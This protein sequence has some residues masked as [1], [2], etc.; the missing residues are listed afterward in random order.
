MEPVAGSTMGLG[1]SGKRITSLYRGRTFCVC[2]LLILQAINN[3]HAEC[4]LF[5]RGYCLCF[6][7]QAAHESIAS[8]VVVRWVKQPAK[9]LQTLNAAHTTLGGSVCVRQRQVGLK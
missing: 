2:K 5:S 1:K 4:V 3:A 9:I 8:T 7:E 6:F